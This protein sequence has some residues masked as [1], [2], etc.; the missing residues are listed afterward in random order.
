[1][2]TLT[3]KSFTAFQEVHP[4]FAT[5]ICR[6]SLLMPRGFLQ[7]SLPLMQTVRYWRACSLLPAM[8][9]MRHSRWI[10]PLN[11]GQDT[12]CMLP[13]LLRMPSCKHAASLSRQLPPQQILRVG[14]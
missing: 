6:L 11:S 7:S 4:F 8:C 14:S 5:M 2:L 12:L 9:I 3:L 1:M 13:A 10:E